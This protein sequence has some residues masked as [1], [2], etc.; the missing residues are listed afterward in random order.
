[1]FIQHTIL[2][3]CGQ[4]ANGILWIQ[5]CE[6]ITVVPTHSTS[7]TS[8]EKLRTAE[9]LEIYILQACASFPMMHHSVTHLVRGL[10]REGPSSERTKECKLRTAVTDTNSF[11]QSWKELKY[12]SKK[13]KQ[14][15]PMLQRTLP[16]PVRSF[17]ST[18]PSYG[19]I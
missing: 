13:E 12:T 7:N 19:S 5:T 14:S 4:A 15:P 1:M 18:P 8:T 6:K 2:C 11:R 3:C 9:H 10:W 17:M 16:E